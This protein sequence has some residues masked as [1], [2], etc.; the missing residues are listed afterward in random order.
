VRKRGVEPLRVL[1]HRILNPARLPIPPLSRLIHARC[2]LYA[3]VTWLPKVVKVNDDRKL[4]FDMSKILV[5][6]PRKI[7]QQALRLALSPD[8]EVQ[9]DVSLSDR[10]PTAVKDYDLAIIDAAALRDANLL[11]TQH[12]RVVQGWKIPKIWIDDA[13]RAQAPARDKLVVLTKPI[14]KETLQ[15]AVATCLGAPLTG[16]QNGTGAQSAKGTTGS[17]GT[18]ASDSGTIQGPA[19]IEL[20]DVVEELPERKSHSRQQRKTK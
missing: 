15:S 2:P 4:Q 14:Q 9:F 11:S 3:Y 13:Q 18:T 17:S 8:H 19:I 16:K 20:V 7:L 6:E 1:P 12:M 10:E 5:I